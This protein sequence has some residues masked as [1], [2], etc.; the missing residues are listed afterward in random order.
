MP[1]N[2]GVWFD[3]HKISLPSRPESEEGDPGD[4]IEWRDL[5]FRSLLRV[6]G[7][8]LAKSEFDD[9]LLTVASDEGRSK[10]DHEC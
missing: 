1:T 8:S 5:G 4:A 3:D 7:E 2:H 9:D 6:C 10:A